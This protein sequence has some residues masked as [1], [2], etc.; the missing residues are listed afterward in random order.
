MIKDSDIS[1]VVQGPVIRESALNITDQTTQLVCAR[2]KSL[3]PRAELILS[4]WENENTEN[5]IYDKCVLSVDPGATWFN[6]GNEGLLNNCNRLI[7]STQ[8]GIKAAT[9]PYVFKIRSDLFVCSSD[10]LNYFD[11]FS[12]YNE[13]Y[14]FVKS[15]ILAFSLYSTTG[16]KTS[17][18]TMYRPFH[19]SD[20]AYFGYKEDLEDLYT[21][22]LTQEPEFSQWFL[23]RCKTFFDIEPD[24]LWKMPPEQYVTSSFLKKHIPLELE[25]TADI[26]NNNKALSTQ[27]LVNNFLVLDQTQFALISLKYVNFQLLFEPLLSE[28]AIFY[29]TFLNDYKTTNKLSYYEY[30][31]LTIESMS[32]AVIYRILNPLLRIIEGKSK[33]I[34]RLIGYFI[35]RWKE[36]NLFQ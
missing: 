11:R 18:F 22:P 28:T 32:R 13:K 8:A 24:R 2:I 20:W 34:S 35:K 17:L 1:I 30:V 5:I 15:R 21:I 12:Q 14:K 31:K 23:T 16:H 6:Y 7:V 4:T 36:K 19:I 27:L 29:S 25:H 10:F 9:R 33:N 26:K 3:F